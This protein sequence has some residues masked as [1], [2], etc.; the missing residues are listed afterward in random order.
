[1]AERRTAQERFWA[2]DFG[3]AY[4]ERNNGPQL[5][6]H[7]TALFARMLRG[8][9]GIA[10]V[11][12]LGCNI[13]LNLQAIHNLQPCIDLKG[14]EINEKAA[15]QAAARGVAEISH[16]SILED[17]S[18]L[19]A[20]DLA[21][22]MGVLIHIAPN[23]LDA[24]YENLDRLSRRYVILCEYY[25]PSPM[26]LPYRGHEDRLFKRDFAGEVMDRTGM[27]LMDYGFVYR[28]DSIMPMD[29]MTWFLLQKP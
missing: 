11:C 21:F 16:G 23:N 24:V 15:A 22:T 2:G 25:N 14:I 9:P 10:S 17:Q 20:V 27:H 8:A 29:D 4:I 12:E 7:K 5:L 3:D 6:A 13:G 28:R 1:M 18:A 19:G 26:T